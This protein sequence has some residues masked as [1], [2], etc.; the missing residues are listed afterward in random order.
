MSSPKM[1][2]KLKHLSSLKDIVGEQTPEELSE[3]FKNFDGTS[4]SS[5]LLPEDYDHMNSS[6][7]SEQSDPAKI[8]RFKNFRKSK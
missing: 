4:E 1:K 6:G 8:A 3:Y 2:S 7:E 5:D